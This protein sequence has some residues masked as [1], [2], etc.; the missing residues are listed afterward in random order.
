MFLM[1]NCTGYNIGC[2]ALPVIQGFF[3]AA[4]GVAACMFDIGNAVMMTGGA[5]AL[6]SA[7]LGIKAQGEAP[8]PV[9]KRFLT[10]IPFDTYL[11]M[12]I[13][14][15]AGILIPEGL[16]V[17]LAPAAQANSFL[18]ML[19]LGLLMKPLE[20]RDGLGL[21][22]G[23]V[24]LRLVY[25][26]V[27]ALLI[28]CFLPVEEEARQVLAVTVFAPVSALAPVY[29]EKFGGDGALAGFAT[30]VTIVIGLAVMSGV[31][32]FL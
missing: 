6:T 14:A 12:L 11:L 29:T 17:Y 27:S 2:F 16:D 30:S 13:L 7:L 19:M 9:W 8:V 26:A 20:S 1:L 4:A 31:A 21:L 22:A 25:A 3:G 10:S 28:V 23:A 5:Y 18:A 32:Y 24:G 15:V